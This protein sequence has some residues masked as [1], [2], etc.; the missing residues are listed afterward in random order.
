[1]SREI[2]TLAKVILWVSLFAGGWNGILANMFLLI[3]PSEHSMFAAD[4]MRVVLL[5]AGIVGLYIAA[6]SI[7]ALRSKEIGRKAYC[8]GII[9]VVVFIIAWYGFNVMRSP[10]F[11]IIIAGVIGA[12]IP[13]VT[14]FAVYK[15]FN[16]R[17]VLKAYRETGGGHSVRSEGVKRRK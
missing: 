15:Y 6:T 13:L 5:A 10:Q 2:P 7:L 17:A 3:S 11:T 4:G 9:A 14:C 12:L 8:Y 16:S 1:M